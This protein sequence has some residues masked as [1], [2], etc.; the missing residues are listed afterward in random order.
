[1]FRVVA[2]DMRG[3][4]NT[5]APEGAEHYGVDSITADLLAL[6][7]HL[8]CEQAIFA[9][10][11]F[12]A[13]AV[14]DLAL[15]APEKVTAIIGL[16]NPAAPH[17]PDIPPLTE[18]AEMA[19]AHFL[20]IE[21]FRPVGPADA[22][23]DAAPRE[24]L[25]KVFYALSGDY[26]FGQVMAHPPGI[27]YLQALPEAPPLPWAWLSEDDFEHYVD[28]YSRSGFTGG[29]NWYRSMDL[30]WQQRKAFEGLQS[31]VPAYFI[32][33][34]YDV[35]LEHFHGDDP[36]SLMRAQFPDLRRVEMIPNAGHLVQLECSAAVNRCMLEFL[37]DI[38]A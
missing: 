37:A 31:A 20:H 23:L 4:G 34:E 10:L 19:K 29:L 25:Q 16:E 24:F 14:Y 26:D 2:P 28:A 11:D 9:G 1:G 17:N 27:T 15:Q 18:Y 36:I 33:S 8:E 6:L 30:K 5:Q 21:Y 38:C 32:G 3:M 35:D 22:D 13:F 12:G 7:L